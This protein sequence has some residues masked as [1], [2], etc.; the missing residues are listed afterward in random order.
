MNNGKNINLI[1]LNEIDNAIRSLN[2]LSYVLISVLWYHMFWQGKCCNLLRSPCQLNQSGDQHK[3][4]NFEQHIHRLPPNARS[5][6][7]SILLSRLQSKSCSHFLNIK[8]S[9]QL[10]ILKPRLN[11]LTNIDS[12]HQIIPGSIFCQLL[13]NSLCLLLDWNIFHLDRPI[14]TTFS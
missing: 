13:D 3:A 8:R 5:L 12:I 4:F 11:C 10:T 6:Y 7:S 14:N 9:T 1:C 2:Y